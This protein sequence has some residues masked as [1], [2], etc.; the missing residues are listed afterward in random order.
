MLSLNDLAK[1]YHALEKVD[2]SGFQRKARLLQSIW[3]EEQGYPIGEHKYKGD[4]R[5]IGSRLAM[6]W[7]EEILAN[8]LTDSIRAVVRN[9][10]L[11]KNKSRGKLY[12][13]PRIF[14]DLLSSQPLCFNLFGELQQDLPLATKVFNDLSPTEIKE[15]TAIEFEYSPGRGDDRYT[16]DRSAFDVYVS[17]LTESGGRGFLG[18]EVKYHENLKGKA[19]PHRERYDQVA[20]IMGCFKIH[21]LSKLREQPLQQIWRDHLLAGIHKHVDDFD[22]GAFVFLYPRENLHCAEAVQ[23][24][25]EKLSNTDSFLTWTLEDVAE[26]IQLH[27]EQEWI[28][29]FIDRYLD[30]SKIITA[31]G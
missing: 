11:D 10:V 17:Y 3:R 1:E 8:Y 30:F 6:P 5:P 31:Q 7:A 25:Q 18:V 19:S 9:E 4:S 28:N 20:E 23:T 21:H 22:E 24:Y 27:S 26:T 16:G 14:N 2:K 29:L 15:V 12:V 13:K